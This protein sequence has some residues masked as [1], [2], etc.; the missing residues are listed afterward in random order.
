MP[1]DVITQNKDFIT[2]LEGVKGFC[3]FIE[4]QQSNNNKTFLLSLQQQLIV[5]YTYGQSLPEFKLPD[6]GDI[7]EVHITNEEI[8]DTL[9][10]IAN[11]L[12]DSYYWIVFDPTDHDNTEA[13]CGDLTDDLGDIYKALKTFTIGFKS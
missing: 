12:P 4:A 5:L 1:V 9:S 7:K 8:K 10:F 6:D 13:V 11:R 3:L 2:F